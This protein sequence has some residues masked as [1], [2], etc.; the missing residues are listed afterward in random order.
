MSIR[1]TIRESDLFPRRTKP[2]TL[3]DANEGHSTRRLIADSA[4][5]EFIHYAELLS[6]RWRLILG[7]TFVVAL[8]MAMAVRVGMPKYYRAQATITPEPPKKWLSD[9]TG[10]SNDKASSSEM[11]Q[12]LTRPDQTDNTLVSQRLVATL[13]SYTFTTDL[14]ERYRLV[15][16]VTDSNETRTA[17]QLFQKISANFDCEYDFVS[18]NLTLYYFDYQPAQARWALRF[19]IEALRDQL[20]QVELAEAK[21]AY[22]SLQAA[23]TTTSDSLLR[24]ELSEFV[25]QQIERASLAQAESNFAFEIVDSPYVPDA[26]AGPS[27]RRFAMIA[28]LLTFLALC[29][30]FT[31]VDVVARAHASADDDLSG[32]E[33]DTTDDHAA[34]AQP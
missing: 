9:M 3:P 27:A 24:T 11:L 29:G 6:Q 12:M 17:W 30:W 1:R 22:T 34:M 23:M 13:R 32:S 5:A 10:V 7:A 26:P 16:P 4:A 25:A 14:Q 33:L 8:A 28:G 2:G 15:S 18:G 31:A 20:R 21:V 19:Y